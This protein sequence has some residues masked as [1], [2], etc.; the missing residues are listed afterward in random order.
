MSMGIIECRTQIQAI[1]QPDTGQRAQEIVLRTE[2]KNRGQ[3]MAE[4]RGS[5]THQTRLTRLT[6]FEIRTRHRIGSLFLLD[7]GLALVSVQDT[8]SSLI[9]IDEIR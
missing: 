1:S 4:E 7:A 2:C 6:G 3:K 8:L 5:R 9:E